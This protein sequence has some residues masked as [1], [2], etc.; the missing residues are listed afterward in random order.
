M[1]KLV[2]LVLVLAGVACLRVSASA[3][4]QAGEGALR[5]GRF[6]AS[7]LELMNV[8]YPELTVKSGQV[9]ISG[10]HYSDGSIREFGLQ[11][12]RELRLMRNRDDILASDCYGRF[13]FDA[14]GL[15]TY[16]AGGACVRQVDNEA[17]EEAFN[18]EKK[19]SD[20]EIGAELLR[21]GAHYPPGHP[22]MFVNRQISTELLSRLLGE[23]L[24]P[25]RVVFRMPEREGGVAELLG[26]ALHW[27]ASYRVV[28]QDNVWVTALYEPFGGNLKAVLRSPPERE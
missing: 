5:A 22:Q 26:Y 21:R 25:G 14:V 19:W 13:T 20:E 18:R 11:Y 17:M 6:I 9:Q 16:Y 23:A 24:E 27:E 7:A 28:G 4:E 10:K 8:A 15:L 3:S 2:S 1:P 12:G